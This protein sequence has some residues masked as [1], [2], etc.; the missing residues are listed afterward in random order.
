MDG[1]RFA[2]RPHVLIEQD[3]LS[4]DVI[5]IDGHTGTMCSCNATA[6]VLLLQLEEG[7]TQ[8]ELVETLLAAFFVIKAAAQRDVGRFLESLSVMGIVEQDEASGGRLAVA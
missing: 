8:E 7:V 5:L 6:A 1:S 2:L 3:P 4:D